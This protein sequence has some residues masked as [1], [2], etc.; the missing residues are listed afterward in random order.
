MFQF[1]FFHC[2]AWFA[3]F[4]GTSCQLLSLPFYNT[5]SLPAMLKSITPNKQ[6]VFI[7]AKN[8]HNGFVFHIKLIEWSAPS[9]SVNR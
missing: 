3:T 7:L 4:G 8:T 2:F 1:R 9:L 5:M 6:L